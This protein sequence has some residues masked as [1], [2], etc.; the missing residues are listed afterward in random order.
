M[1]IMQTYVK[2]ANFCGKEQNICKKWQKQMFKK[3]AYQGKDDIAYR[4]YRENY[5]LY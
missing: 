1:K 3:E 4:L 2:M 5:L